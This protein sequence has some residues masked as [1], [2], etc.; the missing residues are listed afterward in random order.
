MRDRVLPALLLAAVAL[1]AAAQDLLIRAGHVLDVETGRMLAAHDILVREGRIVSITPPAEA[2]G[3][4]LR[5]L[6]WSA[7]IVVPGLMDMHTH[8]ADEG[9]YGDPATPL[10]SNAA[11]DALIG[12]R[13]ARATLQ[14]GFTTVRDV[15]VYRG[16]ADVQLRDAIN[17]GRV[18]GPRMFVAGAY[19]T[20]TGGGGE[21]TGLPA[22]TEVPDTFRRGIA[23]NEAEVR[24][25]VDEILDNGADFIKLIATGAVLADGTEPGQSEYT[26]AEIRAAVEQAEARGSFVAAHAHG[27]EG[28]KRAVRAGARSIE[29]GSLMDDEAIAL[30][31]RHG[32]WLVAD[33]YNGDYIDSV[34]RRDGWSAE[35]LRKNLDTTDAQREGFRK[36]VAAGVDIAYGTD[37]GVYPHG[38]NARQFAYMV[39]H[40]M[41]PLQAIRAATLESARLLRREKELG[42]IA[43]GKAAD[44]VAL[45]CDPLADIAC[46]QQI[47]GVL[48]AGVPVAR[49]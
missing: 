24:R 12:A 49:D 13:N 20:V 5:T 40:G 25:R 23:D 9:P 22:G 39:R 3:P 46:L 15:G 17:A 8:L 36:A 44:L 45:A 47:R 4:G 38:D 2:A 37:S 6:D 34:G 31:K 10:R 19:V 18:P 42:S 11:R 21:I 32:T 26:E 1:P 35:S 33:I 28:I 30:M 29:H 41:T 27:A 14:A 16:F 43:P 7:L 48:K